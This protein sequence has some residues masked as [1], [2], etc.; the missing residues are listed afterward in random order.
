MR[1][2]RTQALLTALVVAALLSGCDKQKLIPNTEVPDTKLNRQVLKVVEEYRKAMGRMDAAKVLTLVH[3]TYQ[4]HS[5]TP[6]GS[7]DIDY[8]GLKKILTGEFKNTSK[9]RF[10][11]EYQAVSTKGR[12]A[13]VDT[14]I[15]ATFVYTTP[16]ANPRW[17]RLTDFNRF[18]LLQDKKNTWRF[19]S[20]L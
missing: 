18:K 12:E 6:E 9:V 5:G 3:P 19:I 16:D 11:I 4:D 20:G 14:Y 8:E 7:D 17:R 10:N 13:M 2:F 1:R 15:D